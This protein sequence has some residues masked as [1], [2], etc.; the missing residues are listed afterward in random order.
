MPRSYDSQMVPRYHLAECSLLPV[1][2]WMQFTVTLC[3]RREGP[4]IFY[5]SYIISIREKH[6]VLLVILITHLHM[7]ISSSICHLD[8][9]LIN[10]I[11]HPLG[12]GY[13]MC[14]GSIFLS[15]CPQLDKI[16]TFIFLEYFAND[17]DIRF[18]WSDIDIKQMP[19]TELY[20]TVSWAYVEATASLVRFQRI[21]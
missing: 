6:D 20:Q 16:N 3:D 9:A 11:K 13:F 15:V 2:P 7:V 18:Y 4:Q 21:H 19:M 1:F 5:V 14:E 17:L 12:Y 8:Y 10:V